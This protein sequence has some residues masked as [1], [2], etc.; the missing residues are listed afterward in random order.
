MNFFNLAGSGHAKPVAAVEGGRPDDVLAGVGQRRH[1]LPATSDATPRGSVPAAK[2]DPKKL[3]PAITELER[4]LVANSTRKPKSIR[5]RTVE[6]LASEGNNG[7]N[8]YPLTEDVIKRVAA[9]LKAAHFGSGALCLG[10]LRLGRVDA[11][12]PV[13]V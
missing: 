8:I 7:R 5:L 9:A 6:H 2:L 4:D 11:K 1:D 10:E 13:P 3:R 12:F